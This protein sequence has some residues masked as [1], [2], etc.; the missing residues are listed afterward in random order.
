MVTVFE[1]EASCVG[2]LGLTRTGGPGE[3]HQLPA[4]EP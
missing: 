4:L 1:V 2:D 3:L